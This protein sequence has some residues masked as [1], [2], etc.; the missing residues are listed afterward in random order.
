[1][2]SLSIGYAHNY[3]DS[4]K[5]VHTQLPNPMIV[6]ALCENVI[7]PLLRNVAQMEHTQQDLDGLIVRCVMIAKVSFAWDPYVSPPAH[8][9]TL[10][11][12]LAY[13]GQQ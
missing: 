11:E 2:S 1:M 5:Y 12:C 10:P 13:I 7:G 8:V 9:P 4:N 6:L 3:A